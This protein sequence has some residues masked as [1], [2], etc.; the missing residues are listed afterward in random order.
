MVDETGLALVGVGQDDLV[1]LPALDQGRYQAANHAQ[2]SAQTQ[3]GI[4]FVMV[5]VVAVD[6]L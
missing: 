3:L 1:L 6:L 2:F 5:Q 4:K